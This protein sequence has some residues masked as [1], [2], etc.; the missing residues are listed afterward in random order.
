MISQTETTKASRTPPDVETP[1]YSYLTVFHIKVPMASLVGFS[2]PD[3][4]NPEIG[5]MVI[6]GAASI[7]REN[8]S[9]SKDDPTTGNTPPTLVTTKNANLA[10][11][12]GGVVSP[13]LTPFHI[14]NRAHW[15][16]FLT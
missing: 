9:T 2:S 3:E 8:S 13:D 16:E 15:T 6:D 1:N 4:S 7:S 5:I 10:T 11:F 14:E 12:K